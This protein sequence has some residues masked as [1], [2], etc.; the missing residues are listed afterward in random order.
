MI[1]AVIIHEIIGHGLVSLCLGGEFTGFSIMPDGMG[2]AMTSGGRNPLVDLA[3]GVFMTSLFGTVALIASFSRRLSPL[4]R[5]HCSVL[6]LMLLLEGVPYTFWNSVFPRPPGDIGK[7]LM[8]TAPNSG[9]RWILCTISGLAFVAAVGFGS[10]ALWRGLE[11]LLGS[12]DSR[13]AAV[14]MLLAITLPGVAYNF[15][16][17]WNQ[18]IE[19]V[20]LI[21]SLTNAVL[22]ALAAVFLYGVRARNIEPA[23][24]PKATWVLCICTSWSVCA[25]LFGA[26][27]LWMRHGVLI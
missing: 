12:M 8:L 6:A 14:I 1:L 2:W 24:V 18:I 3:G 10:L 27:M 11:Q 13:R 21:P 16:F 22:Q 4:L 7:I 5:I 19:D 15:V 23:A 9:V 20:G 25:G 17:D 26:V